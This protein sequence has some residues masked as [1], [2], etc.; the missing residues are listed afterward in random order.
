MPTSKNFELGS[1]A[2]NVDHD[3][4]TGDT[5][6]SN[7]ITLTGEL[8]G[9][10]TFIID[11]A[12]VGDATGLLQIKGNL[13]V[14]GTT[15]TINSTTLD[16]DDLNITVAKGAANAAAADGAGLTVDGANA[17]FTYDASNDRWTMN[18][19]LFATIEGMSINDLTD[20]DTNTTPPT[21]GQTIVWNTTT[22]K[23]EPGDSFS[24]SDF[25]TAFA[26]KNVGDLNDVDTTGV[27]DGQVLVYSLANSRF[28]P[29]T[30]SGGGGGGG[31][32]F[33]L[34]DF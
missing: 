1:F 4:S 7:N 23:F 2:N 28:E 20:V 26:A 15:T 8:R 22:A 9:P 11:P 31:G 16:V 13:Q 5:E 30:V 27:T 34:L 33:S 24:Q 10:S 14:D 25:N 6:I 17:T 32:L 3:P 12:A 19:S 29:G 18:K 21:N